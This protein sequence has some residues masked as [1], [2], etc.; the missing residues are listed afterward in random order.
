[1]I[2]KLMLLVGF[3]ILIGTE[4]IGDSHTD[5][6]IGEHERTKFSA[7][8]PQFDKQNA[9]LADPANLWDVEDVPMDNE[10]HEPRRKI[11]SFISNEGEMSFASIGTEDGDMISESIG[12]VDNDTE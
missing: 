1:M 11:I 12:D 9:L 7:N 10:A 5:L 2:L 4:A 3:W 8:S 6:N